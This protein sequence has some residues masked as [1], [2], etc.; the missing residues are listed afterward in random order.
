MRKILSVSVM[1]CLCFSL[2][3]PP[4]VLEAA[5]S[6]QIAEFLCERGVTYL[7]QNNSVQALI[8][9]KK[10]LLADPK[11]VIAREYIAKIEN[12]KIVVE[13][14][15][16]RVDEAARCLVAERENSLS[17]KGAPRVLVPSVK[18]ISVEKKKQ[19]SDIQRAV[20]FEKKIA[21]MPLPR[22]SSKALAAQPS[23]QELTQLEQPQETVIDL[24]DLEKKGDFYEISTAVDD[25]LVMRSQKIEKFVQ[26]DPASL[27]V[28][29]KSDGEIIVE[30]RSYGATYMYIWDQQGRRNIK[31][32]V[33]P[34]RISEYMT[35]VI[36]ERQREDELP[37]SFKVSYSI[38]NDT[39]YTG[40]R[41]Y[42]VRK[43]SSPY[44]YTSSVKGETPYGKLNAS[45]QGSRTRES[46][47]Y[48]PNIHLS[49]TD[50][51]Y[52]EL[53]DIDL[54]GFDF[55]PTFSAFNFP[56]ADLRGASISAPMCQN[57]FNYTT[58]WGSLPEGGFTALS[59]GSGL[60]KRKKAW[61]EG[62]GLNYKPWSGL[63]LKSYFAHSYGSQREQ[64]VWTNNTMGTG[65]D[66]ALGPF[67][68]G[69]EMASDMTHKSYTG[70]MGF[71]VPKWNLGLSMTD[72]N[73]DFASLFGGTPASGNIGGTLN[74]NFRPTQ[75]L[76]ISNAFGAN[77]DRVFFNPDDPTRPN[78]TGS[79]RVNWYADQHTEYEIGYS[80]EDRIGSNTPSVTETKDVIARKQFY[81]FR[82]MGTFLSY[83]NQKAKYY[84]SSA[85]DFNNN[86]ITA[87][88]SFRV[89]SELYYY[90]NREFNMLRNNF[91]GETASPYGEEMGLN[92][93]RQICQTPFY[94]RS[95]IAYRNENNT[96][97]WLSYLSGE[98][99]LEGEGELTYR[100]MPDQEAFLRL[101]V[102][103]I[104]AEK[105]GVEKHFDLDLALG[106]R[107]LWDTG[108]RW[109]PRG[110]F[111]GVV[112]YDANGDG[113]RQGA[114]K[115][116]EGVVIKALQGQK[117]KTNT[118]GI[119]KI[120]NVSGKLTTLELDTNSLPRGYGA[121]TT[122]SKEVDIVHGVTQRVD[123][124]V[125]THMEVS[126]IVFFDKNG[127]GSY[128]PG[129]DEAAKAVGII[130]DGKEKA[131]TSVLGEYMFRQL[132]SGEHTVVLDLKSIPV[133]YIPKVP[134]KK[135]LQVA[136]GETVNYNIPLVLQAS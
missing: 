101:R 84:T 45:I 73:R 49:L 44:T 32:I 102:T 65:F 109:M 131:V 3:I 90:Y 56:I 13:H 69:S 86:R 133:K 66:Y 82:K 62:V 18:A 123:F 97:S 92:F 125:A 115:G 112:F 61:L 54:Y 96:E 121:T 87:G 124:G 2:V 80:L 6:P 20:L 118:Q 55:T 93:Y 57:K 134:V 25:S 31:F 95:R 34:K 76:N 94:L 104:W 1:L 7:S 100:P 39:F 75:S 110:S 99:R 50:A 127:D 5:V 71:R 126:G 21:K 8:E 28:T 117:A 83:Q 29:R 30:P 130:F 89:L 26:T 81:F 119:Y 78:Y 108:F 91:T 27:S 10:A 77:R 74:L 98:D 120:K 59:T 4:G 105:S 17:E 111:Q 9:F 63:S 40:R 53:R 67:S 11:S 52:G 36:E 68:I 12:Q 113:A 128:D 72:N 15:F 64:P 88:I 122:V 116:V 103:N 60:S 106:V 37:D 43:V 23:P 70:R 51:H 22:T 33:G 46:R 48:I 19:L 135:T 79:T 38:E 35:R 24:K 14:R 58:F 41:L 85:Q 129:T 136:E 16:A 114:E 132:A 47:Y 107:L 42:N